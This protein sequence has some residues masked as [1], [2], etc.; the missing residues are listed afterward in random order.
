M[1]GFNVVRRTTVICWDF[2]CCDSF[3]CPTL[4]A[5]SLDELPF[6]QVV[7]PEHLRGIVVLPICI[8][9]NERSWVT[10][11]YGLWHHT[12]LCS[13]LCAPP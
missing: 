5:I 13:Q 1:S 8:S 6:C 3:T 11:E 4:L 7:F 2:C 10:S 12:P 9:G